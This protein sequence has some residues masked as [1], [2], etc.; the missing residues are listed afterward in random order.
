MTALHE[1]RRALQPHEPWEV[2]AVRCSEGDQAP[3]HE[4]GRDERGAV[5]CAGGRRR[6]AGLLGCDGGA[7]RYRRRCGLHERGAYRSA[8]DVARRDHAGKLQPVYTCQAYAR[9]GQ[10]I[11]DCMANP[12]SYPWPQRCRIKCDRLP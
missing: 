1:K 4:R 7:A 2:A 5:E 12:R 10:T 3:E 9:G 11:G 8:G 6:F